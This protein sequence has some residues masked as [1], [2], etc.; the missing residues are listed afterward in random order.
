MLHLLECN[1]LIIF[2]VCLC[3]NR[4]VKL[5][6]IVMPVIVMITGF[7]LSSCTYEKAKLKV[8]CVL[9]DTVSFGRNIQPIFNAY[10]NGSGC[11]NSSSHSG[12][13]N[14]EAPVAYS[15]LLAHGTGYIDTLNPE[16]SLL[17]SKLTSA[18]GIMPPSGRLDDCKINLV[19]E[20]IKQK[21]KNN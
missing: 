18:S 15:Q 5:R 16:F 14:L 12:S 3:M 19:L 21:A 10:C 13:L 1:L 7:T 6:L 17:Y 2:Q 11:H 20:W 8:N 4:F 9:P